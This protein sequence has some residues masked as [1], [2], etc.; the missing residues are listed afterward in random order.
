MRGKVFYADVTGGQYGYWLYSRQNRLVVHTTVHFSNF[1]ELSDFHKERL[2]QRF[3]QAAL[4][5]EKHNPFNYPVKFVFQIVEDP[6]RAHVRN[7]K[8][9][10]NTRGPYFS[11]WNI[12]WNVATI[13]HEF[14]HVL[15]LDDEYSYF[16]QDVK[17]ICEPTSLMC[18][19]NSFRSEIKNYHYYLVLRRLG[20]A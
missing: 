2:Q 5:W 7:I 19:T 17:G 16:G 3:E 4:I 6:E 18:Q 12:N 8:L 13:A 9:L 1:N 15:G 20:C 11:K 14:G 10:S